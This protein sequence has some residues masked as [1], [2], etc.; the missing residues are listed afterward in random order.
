[1]TPADTN[2]ASA[3]GTQTP[4]KAAAPA[5]M[6]TAADMRAQANKNKVAVA[7]TKKYQASLSPEQKKANHTA[8]PGAWGSP[9]YKKDKKGG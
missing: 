8:A 1:V 7:K 5:K 9:E 6:G 4:A 2:S 3:R